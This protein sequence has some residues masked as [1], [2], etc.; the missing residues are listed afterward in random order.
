[1]QYSYV[2]ILTNK[3][4]TTLY[5]G[6]TSDLIKRVWQHKNKTAGS[7]TSRYNV[8]KLVYFEVFEDITEAIK[9]EKQIKSGSRQDKIDLIISENSQFNDLYKQIASG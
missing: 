4:N 8:T 3:T 9:R 7:F 1:M 2:Y 5:T 6:V